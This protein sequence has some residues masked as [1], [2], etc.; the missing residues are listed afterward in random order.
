MWLLGE[1]RTMEEKVAEKK[2]WK[3]GAVV[4]AE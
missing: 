4:E 3:E 1:L 2:R